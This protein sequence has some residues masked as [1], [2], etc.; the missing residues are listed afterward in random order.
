MFLRG[1]VVFIYVQVSNQQTAPV[2]SR[3][4]D[5]LLARE[6]S[7]SLSPDVLAIRSSDTERTDNKDSITDVS[8]S[9]SICLWAEGL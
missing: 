1:I 5:K 4:A 3:Q 8:P 6:R 7:L 2:K 9:S